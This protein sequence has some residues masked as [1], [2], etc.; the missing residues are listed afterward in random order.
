MLKDS[1]AA[2]RFTVA[3]DALL[4]PNELTLEQVGR[5]LG[6]LASGSDLADLYFQTGKSESWLLREEKVTSGSYSIS[7]GVGARAVWGDRTAF[8]YSGD[9]S[10]Q[11]LGA[12]VRAAHG[13]RRQA[14]DSAATGG[15]NIGAPR[16]SLDLYPSL[17]PTNTMDAAGKIRLL[18]EVDRMARA[19]DP[20]IVR[21]TA[22]LRASHRIVLLAASDGTLAADIRPNAQLN[23][24]VMAEQN[25][26]RASGSA[27]VGGRFAVSDLSGERLKQA[28]ERATRIALRSLEARPAPAGVMSVVLGPGFPGVLLHEAVGHGLEGDAHRIKSSVFS[29][30]MN[31][32]IAAKGVTV[33]DDGSLPGRLGSL[34]LDD[35]GAA[36]RRTVLIEDGVLA[37]LMQDRLNARLMN[38]ATTGNARRQSYAHLPMPRM[39]NTFLAPGEYDPMEIISSVKRGIYAAAFG[40]GTVDITSGQFNFSATEA[41]LI[42]DGKITAPI[43][44]ATLIGLGHE[45]LNHIS[46]VGRD[47]ELD[48][49]ICR[50]SGQTVSVCVGQPTVRIDNM[51]VGGTS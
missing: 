6:D 22:S 45:A 43:E 37:G 9:I 51:V 26:R 1:Q 13:M 36:T 5:S 50:K 46:M 12:V 39:T 25:G 19:A 23:I 21:V 49:G 31:R 34:N 32:R 41:Y 28:I 27:S 48:N 44:G 4:H 38:Q 8:A 30:K 15:T 11:A 3:D 2:D 10:R 35:E 16:S 20:R 47:L 42:E 33:V 7:Q 17:D 14:E 29:D 40:G 18:Q 24:S